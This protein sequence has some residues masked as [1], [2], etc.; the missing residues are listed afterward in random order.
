MFTI[1]LDWY[2]IHFYKTTYGMLRNT[3]YKRW[4]WYYDNKNDNKEK[5][6]ISLALQIFIALILGIIVVLISQI[7]WDE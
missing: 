4:G 2:I 1:T 3:Y 7:I 6:K 5:R